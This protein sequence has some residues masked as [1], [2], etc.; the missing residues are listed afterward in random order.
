MLRRLEEKDAPLMLEWMYD[1]EINCNFR[2]DFA[3]ATLESAK[4]FIRGSFTDKD[5]NF[6]FVDE[7]DEYMGTISLKNISYEDSS[8]EYAVVARKKA[9]GTGAAMRATKELLN[10]AFEKLKL[11]KVYL[12][13]LEENVRAQR[14][15]EKCGFVCEGSA[16]DAVKIKGVYRT[17]K[18]YGI[19]NER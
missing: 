17:L 16:V 4:E 15:Y 14:L 18:W 19:I 1:S 11:H 10:Y 3:S 2:A 5:M 6:A 12:N 8:A 7:N 13:V 9:Q